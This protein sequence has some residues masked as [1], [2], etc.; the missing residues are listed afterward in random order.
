MS[1]FNLASSLR[2]RSNYYNPLQLAY[3]S[4]PADVRSRDWLLLYA[5]F[6]VTLKNLHPIQRL[7]DVDRL[8]FS[9]RSAGHLVYLASMSAN[10]SYSIITVQW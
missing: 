5:K 4:F 9:S 3:L 10:I 2:N 8:P 7:A 6:D 1:V